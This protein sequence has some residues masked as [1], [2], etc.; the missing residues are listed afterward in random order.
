MADAR[1]DGSLSGL[2]EPE[3]REFHRIFMASFIVFMVIAI[4]AHFL[5]WQWRPWLPDETGFTSMLESTPVT[6]VT[7]GVQV[8]EG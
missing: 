2:T 4:I 1:R 5:V 7:T 8:R 3:A 6:V